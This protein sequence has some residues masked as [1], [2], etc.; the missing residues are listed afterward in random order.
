MRKEAKR[1]FTQS[2]PMPCKYCGKVIRCNMYRHVARLHLDLAQLW[3]CPESWCTVWKGTPQDCMEHLRNG[4]DVP[5]ISRT[6]SIE[7]FVPPWTVRRELWTESLR[8]EHS[9]ISTDIMLFSD[10]GL[11]LT[12]HYRVY[13]GGLPHAAFRTD[14]MTRLRALLPTPPST[15][16]EPTSPPET[17][18]GATPR[19]TR[20]SH[21]P[22]RPVPVMSEAVGELPIL[23]IQDPT[24]M[25]GASVVDCRPPVLP[26]SIPLNALS[27]RTVENARGTSGF[28]PSRTEGQSIMDMDTNEIT[29][30]RIVAFPW[31]DPGTDVEDELPM[32][33][34]S[35]VQCTTPAVMTGESGGP[36]EL[37]DNFELDL[38][39]VLLDVS[40]MLTMVSPIENSV[41][42]ET[43]E[44]AEYAAPEAPTIET[45]TESPGFTVPQES[46]ILTGWVPRYSPISMTSSVGGEARPMSTMQSSPYIPPVVAAPPAS[47]TETL[48]QFI[49]NLPS[50]LGV[51]SQSP[52]RE[53]T[54]KEPE[55]EVFVVE[56]STESPSAMG[57]Q[58]DQVGR[59]DLSR[60]GPF[61]VHDVPTTSGQDPWI[62]N[63]LPGCQ[64]RM[65]SYDDR[66][67]HADL[68][69]AYGIHLHD[70]RMMEY[71]GAPESARLLGRTPEYCLEHMGRERTVAAA[72]RLHH[73]T[74]LI[75]TNVQ[76]MAQFVT[77]LNRTASEV[78]RVV[79]EKEPFPTD[80]VQYVTPAR[81][82][83]RAAH[84]MAA[85]GLWR[86]TSGPVLP[87]PLPVS[88]CNSCMSCE[89]CFV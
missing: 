63:S 38:A 67:S 85:M 70:P 4:H 33:A 17:V 12:H 51:P 19:S 83:R 69:P 80:A 22:F 78:M 15:N 6:A 36:P 55:T 28:N 25:A 35:P 59:S 23:T 14:Y 20:R 57:R 11:S 84:Y 18:R 72:L 87:G 26:V 56:T 54:T 42:I 71:M 61:E 68:D 74:S 30:N 21:R 29:I 47:C 43:T 75:M 82:V 48:D 49:P 27:P 13:R 31:N 39:K 86:P 1:V 46:G 89:D 40:V 32:P 9:G 16:G 53:D 81:R 73:D 76:V 50:P 10:L 66:D 88:S 79:Y 58:A 24:D 52:G 37:R 5:W 62:L 60:E 44:V 2:R 8:L 7:R 65:T 45:V 41:V 34:S 64:Y 77:G 3:R